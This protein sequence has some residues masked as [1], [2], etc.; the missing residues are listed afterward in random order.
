MII[1]V[2]AENHFDKTQRSFMIKTLNKLRI[3]GNFLNLMNLS[4]KNL[5]LTSCDMVEIRQ[6]CQLCFYLALY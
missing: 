4:M 2:D 3:E 1:S 6:G 5:Q